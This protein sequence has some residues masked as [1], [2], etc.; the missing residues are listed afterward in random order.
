MIIIVEILSK[1]LDEQASDEI[2][3]NSTVFSNVSNSKRISA[4]NTGIK[5]VS[6]SSSSVKNNYRNK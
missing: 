3:L 1:D 5:R 2:D 4:E 6:K